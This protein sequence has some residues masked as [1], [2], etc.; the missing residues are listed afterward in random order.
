MRGSKHALVFRICSTCSIFDIPLLLYSFNLSK[1]LANFALQDGVEDQ[2]RDNDGVEDRMDRWTWPRVEWL[3]VGIASY[4][5]SAESAEII[6]LM[7][8]RQMN[9]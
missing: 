9:R 7:S 1:I 8:A 5:Q 6:T 3:G 2:D 4:A